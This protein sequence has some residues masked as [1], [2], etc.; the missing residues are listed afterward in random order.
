MSAFLG[1]CRGR[2][3][4]VL[5]STCRPSCCAVHC[6]VWMERRCYGL[7]TSSCKSMCTS[8]LCLKISNSCFISGMLHI[9]FIYKC[10]FPDWESDRNV[11]ARGSPVF[12]FKRIDPFHSNFSYLYNWTFDLNFLGICRFELSI[13]GVYSRSLECTQ[14]ECRVCVIGSISFNSPCS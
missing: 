4:L 1:G 3:A 2:I 6:V 13:Q 5:D 14:I 9:V 10:E 11:C 7:T 8:G 12:E